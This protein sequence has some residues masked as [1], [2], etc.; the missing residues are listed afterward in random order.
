MG[1]ECILVQIGIVISKSTAFI[2]RLDSISTNGT[3]A[4]TRAEVII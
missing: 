1:F 4:F 2:H 3:G